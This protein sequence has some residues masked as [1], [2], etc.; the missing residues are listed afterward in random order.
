[1]RY[2]MLSIGIVVV[3]LAAQV[4]VL[5]VPL[6]LQRLVDAFTQL[7]PDAF[8]LTEFVWMYVL[9][10]PGLRLLSW[11][12]WRVSGYTASALR[13]RIDRDMMERAFRA[14]LDQSYRFFS[15]SFTGSLVR[16]VN[17]LPN[18]FADLADIFW[19]TI[20][21]MFV[22]VF[23]GMIMLG[24]RS[25]V[26]A[27][28]VFLWI[29]TALIG[30]VIVSR[31]KLS[32]DTARAAAQTR[33][34]GA[35]ADAVTNSINISLFSGRQYEEKYFDQLVETHT[36]LRQR[37]WRIGETGAV[38]QNIIGFLCELAVMALVV[39]YWRDGI[40][41]VGEIV[42]VQ[43]ILLVMFSNTHDLGRTVRRVYEAGADTYEMLDILEMVPEIRD[44][45]G[46]KPLSI[47]RGVIEFDRVAFAYRP[48]HGIL[49]D[50]SLSI[51][52]KQKVA[53]VGTSGSGKTTVTK[54]LFRFFDIQG[55]AIKID[56]QDISR[57]TQESLRKVISYVPQEPILFHRTLMEN[58][59]YGRRD[60]T[61]KEVI[62]AAK[63]AHCHEFIEASPEEYETLVGERGIKLSGGE[64]QRVAI[65][66]AILKDA[67]ILVLDE[68]T[69]SLDS[70]SE[71][72]IQDALKKLMRNKTVIVIAHRL[73]TI[74]EM[75]R[76]IVMQEG[77]IVDEG[78]HESLRAK[79][80]IYQ[81]LWNI[82]AG[83]FQA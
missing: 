69:S 2:P 19:W 82:Q 4:T 17:S 72:L 34:T 40:M 9:P 48:K 83:G 26:F 46:A 16:R 74:M 56:G 80:G 39:S 37:S 30:Q 24:L 54:L 76:I 64:R 3:I 77:K 41:T 35:A 51:P 8:S 49:Q 61:D 43:G 66:R 1:M 79:V 42:F 11:L 27:G 7:S 13:P 78:T 45:R 10:I 25:P 23:G 59:R 21:P 47:K 29:T 68:A 14:V 32:V 60:A 50:F 44:K 70:E 52:A 71:S 22:A 12:L 18:A 33:M 81:K 62:E 31:I 36:K 73:S 15:D 6:F 67:P 65:A 57:V 38:L 5:F 20:I 75:D 28:I 53:L 58:I 55:G 63:L